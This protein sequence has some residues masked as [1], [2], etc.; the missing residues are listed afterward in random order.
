MFEYIFEVP[1]NCRERY[2]SKKK[3]DNIRKLNC[4]CSQNIQ[5]FHK[6]NVLICLVFQILAT[7][8]LS[9]LICT[10][11]VNN[12]NQ[13]HTY[14]ESCLRSQDKL[15][16]WLANQLQAKSTVSDLYVIQ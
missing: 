14:K 10:N 5:N 7:D 16:E 9:T 12:V 6:A 2:I 11:C 3:V 13:W 4:T 8:K 1:N 15:H